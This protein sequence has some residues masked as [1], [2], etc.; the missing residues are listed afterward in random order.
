MPGRAA[1]PLPRRAK[2]HH[3]QAKPRL[4][5]LTHYGMTVWRAHP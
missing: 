3:P 4:A 2:A 1:T 5:I